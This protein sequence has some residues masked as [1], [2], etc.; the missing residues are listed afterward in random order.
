LAQTIWPDEPGQKSYRYV[1]QVDQRARLEL[2]QTEDVDAHGRKKSFTRRFFTFEW[3]SGW[4]WEP[5]STTR[6]AALFPLL[7]FVVWIVIFLSTLAQSTL[8]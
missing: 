5:V 4:R 1:G 3:L 7:L 6:L 8:P 2:R